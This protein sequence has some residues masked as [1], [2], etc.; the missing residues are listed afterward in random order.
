MEADKIIQ[1]VLFDFIKSHIPNADLS[2]IDD[3]ILSY[4]TG[5]LEDLGS[6]EREE[7]SFD[8]EMLVEMLEAYMPGFAE[9]ESVHVYEMM[10]KLAET[11]ASTRKKGNSSP[12]SKSENNQSKDC[13]PRVHNED[14][15][16]QKTTSI[17]LIGATAKEAFSKEDEQVQLLLEMFPACSVKEAQTALSI[18]KW[19]LEE[20]VQLLIAGDVELS[21]N[22]SSKS[23]SPPRDETLK[24]GILEKYMLMDEDDNKIHRPFIPK[25][26]PKKLVRYLDNRVVSTKG[27]RYQQI[28]KEES[29]DLKKTYINLKPARKY[30]FH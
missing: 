22:T 21:G 20:A 25:E 15:C 26:A 29:E 24:A 2:T 5:V 27:E 23:S 30:R 8:V 17:D 14:R 4:I 18:A 1:S 9:I 28:K 11:L 12:E 19:E 16:N 13:V 3:V 10:I 6:P 7:E